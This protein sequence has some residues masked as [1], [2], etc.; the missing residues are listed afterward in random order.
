M[1][2]IWKGTDHGSS[3]YI[4][5]REYDPDYNPELTKKKF[6]YGVARPFIANSLFLGLKYHYFSLQ[7]QLVYGT[8]YSW[9]L[10]LQMN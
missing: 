2:L 9:N 7:G 1:N 8:E 4:G 6:I 3:L 5:I 10:R